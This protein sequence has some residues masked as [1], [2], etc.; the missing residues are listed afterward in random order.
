MNSLHFE[1]GHLELGNPIRRYMQNSIRSDTKQW[2]IYCGYS[3]SPVPDP[4]SEGGMNWLCFWGIETHETLSKGRQEFSSIESR[5]VFWAFLI[6]DG[7][8]FLAESQCL[9]KK[10]LDSENSLWGNL[11]FGLRRQLLNSDWKWKI[12]S[13]VFEERVTPITLPC[14][15]YTQ[16]DS[17][18]FT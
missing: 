7:Q 9:Q 8:L 15:G 4:M 6:D 12:V 11:A 16:D 5:P 2:F 3:L 18:G 13:G 1:K 17:G 14:G 10:I